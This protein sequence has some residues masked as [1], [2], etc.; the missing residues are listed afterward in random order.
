MEQAILHL[1]TRD[2]I[3]KTI[4]ETHGL[5]E[6]PFRPQ[7]FQTLSLLILEQQVSV[8]SAKATFEKL[9]KMIPVFDPKSILETS[10]SDFRSCG[11]SRQKTK[12]IKCLAEAILERS[13]DLDSLSS[14]S[15]LEVRQ[16]LIKIKGIG[17]W[18]IDVYLMFSL[19]ASDIL[20]LG[21]I[22]VFNTIKE[23]LNIRTLIEM[24]KYSKNWAPYRTMATFL[25]W[26]HYLKKR[27]RTI[28]Y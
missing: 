1:S 13:I 24:E 14:K 7:G 23:L 21:D 20:P 25:L 27:N 22:A 9:Q 4:V 28:S 17:N 19:K 26:H 3:F 8:D 10:D 16:E 6:I 5:P 2:Q 12:Y 11:V 15:P 18:T